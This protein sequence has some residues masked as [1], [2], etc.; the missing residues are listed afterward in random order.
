MVYLI[1]KCLFLLNQF[2]CFLFFKRNDKDE[3]GCYWRKNRM[4][5]VLLYLFLFSFRQNKMTWFPLFAF[6]PFIAYCNFP[7]IVFIFFKNSHAASILPEMPVP[8]RPSPVRCS[9][10]RAH[11]EFGHLATFWPHLPP[12]CIFWCCWCHFCCSAASTPA[13][14]CAVLPLR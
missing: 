11:R 13:F 6:P 7:S 10:W 12:H 3:Y 4:S 14:S 5:K 8:T 9:P 2:R 1:P